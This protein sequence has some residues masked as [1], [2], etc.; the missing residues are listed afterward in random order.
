MSKGTRVDNECCRSFLQGAIRDLEKGA[1]FWPIGDE[2]AKLIEEIRDLKT[3][4]K[5]ECP[6]HSKPGLRMA[7]G[8]A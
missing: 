5:A 1:T 6:A 4:V 7:R 8:G 3:R 2:V